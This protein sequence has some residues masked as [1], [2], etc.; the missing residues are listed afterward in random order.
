MPIMGKGKTKYQP[1]YVWDLAT[2]ILN[3]SSNRQKFQGKTFEIG[4]PTGKFFGALNNLISCD[5]LL[6]L[7][8]LT[9]V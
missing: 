9:L 7:F 8:F 2:A 1:V 3:I 5:N 4:G 6:T